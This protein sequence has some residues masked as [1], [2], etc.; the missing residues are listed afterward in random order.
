MLAITW[1]SSRGFHRLPHYGQ[2]CRFTTLQPISRLDDLFRHQ[3]D[4]ALEVAELAGALEAG[5]AFDVGVD[6]L[7]PVRQRWGI[8]GEVEP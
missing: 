8:E 5:A 1:F 3:L 7:D 4:Q 2:I 6:D